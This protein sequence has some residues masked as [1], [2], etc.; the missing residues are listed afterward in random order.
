MGL[1]VGS[2]VNDLNV[3]NPV[4][5]TDQKAQGDD[6]LRLIKSVLKATFPLA[7]GAR[8]FRDDDAGAGLTL[9]WD[10][11][12][13]SASPAAADLIAAYDISFDSSTAVKR[14]GLRLL[15]RLDDQINA[16]EDTSALLQIMVAGTL[17]TAM[18]LGAGGTNF[19]LPLIGAGKPMT[20]QDITASG[21]WNR[22]AGCRFIM[23][24]MQGGGGG[25]GAV[26]GLSNSAGATGGGG[27]GFH[28]WTPFIDVTAIASIAFTIGAA[29]AAGVAP[30]GNGGA[31][32]ATTATINAV[33]YSAGGGGGS[34]GLNANG[35]IGGSNQGG[36]A[37]VGSNLIGFASP[38]GISVHTIDTGTGVGNITGG[39][40]ASTPWGSGGFGDHVFGSAIGVNSAA[41]AGKGSG[42]SGGGMINTTG[43]MPGQVGAIG[44]ARVW[45]LY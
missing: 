25:S 5:G 33:P 8:L 17:T 2:F 40:G 7:V 35:T 20:F 30:A 16:T 45:E 41:G 36:T 13:K 11:H 27:G 3:A 1:E 24:E 4:G 39:N 9:T 10:L 22:P 18:T 42:A 23:A 19:L 44:M 12:R 6:H 21:N 38:G 15:A 14:T 34:P 28:G 26:N 32:G 29:G 43:D 31:G 37:G